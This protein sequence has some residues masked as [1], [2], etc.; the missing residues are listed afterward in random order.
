MLVNAAASAS[1]VHINLL[2]QELLKLMHSV[3]LVV[4]TTNANKDYIEWE[5]CLIPAKP[6]A[7]A[8]Q[9]AKK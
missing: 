1:A 5:S 7:A 8:P 3:E 4:G 9:E 2:S 6:E